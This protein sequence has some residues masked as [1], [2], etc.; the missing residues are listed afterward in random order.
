MFVLSDRG[1]VSERAC[2]QRLAWGDKSDSSAL[3]RLRAR[4]DI[5]FFPSGSLMFSFLSTPFRL[6]F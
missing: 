3:I 4:E 5:N 1:Y 6:F 2:Y